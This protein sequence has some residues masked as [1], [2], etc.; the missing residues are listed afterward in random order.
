MSCSIKRTSS[1]SYRSGG[2]GGICGGGAGRSSSVSCRRYASSVI[3]G[4][5]SAGGACSIGYGGGMSAGSLAGGFA[6]GLAG[7]FGAGMGG[8]FGGG[9]AGSFGMGGDALLSG[10]E[11]V[12][13]QNLNDRL[14]S[15]LDKVR[16]LEEENAQLEHHIREWYRK[17]APTVSKDY[18]SYY[19]TIEQLQNQ[20]GLTNML[21]DI[22]NSKMTADDFRMK[23]ENEL[24]I[25]QTVEADVNGLRNLLD[26][27]TH[28]RSS[29]ESEL[30][31]LKE[32]LIAIKRNH[33]EFNLKI[34]PLWL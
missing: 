12:T 11:K 4:G 31:S 23:Y 30:E 15:Y 9:F 26:E 13:M 24:V 34:K 19:Q 32:E 8:G 21:L 22:D 5:S 20:V 27:L 33:E 6:G 14:A 17:Q 18:S 2:A 16:R 10:N 29:L 7:G 25:R 28:T 1:T 3:G